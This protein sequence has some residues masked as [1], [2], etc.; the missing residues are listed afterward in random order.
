VRKMAIAIST[1]ALVLAGGS[2]VEAQVR[3]DST[4]GSRPADEGR[5]PQRDDRSV[6]RKDGRA[7]SRTVPSCQNELRDYS[8][9]YDQLEQRL[10]REHED[11]HRARDRDRSDDWLKEH[12][13]L[14]EKRD[15]ERARWERSN[16]PPACKVNSPRKR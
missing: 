15:R 3:A 1:I 9:R 7:D 10:Y 11:W 6:G 4:R 12:Q 8:R 14:H 5:S 13:A 16:R 2:A